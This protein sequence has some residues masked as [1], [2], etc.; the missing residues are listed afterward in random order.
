MSQMRPLVGNMK[1]QAPNVLHAHHIKSP[2]ATYARTLAEL[3][4]SVF[5]SQSATES[6]QMSRTGFM[7]VFLLS[8]CSRCH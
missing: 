6:N 8:K 5:S 3:L 1:Q 7:A 4:E 2:T